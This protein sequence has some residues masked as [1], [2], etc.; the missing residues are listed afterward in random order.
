MFISIS[1]CEVFYIMQ[2]DFPTTKRN[3]LCTGRTLAGW[4]RVHGL[5]RG[6][7]SA[8]LNEKFVSKNPQKGVYAQVITALEKDGFLVLKSDKGSEKAA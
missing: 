4:G 3:L 2:I 7:V 6:S 8:I 1:D 5:P